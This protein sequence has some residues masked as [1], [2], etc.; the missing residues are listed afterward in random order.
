MFVSSLAVLLCVVSASAT[1]TWQT[2]SP[3]NHFTK[4]LAPGIFVGGRVTT[5]E[6]AYIAE[7][8]YKS[9]L[10]TTTY[11]SA[12][13]IN[14]VTGDFPSVDEEM[15]LAKSLGM[16]AQYFAASFTAEWAETISQAIHQ[17]PKPIFIHC[18]VGYKGSLFTELHLYLNGVVAADDIYQNTLTLGWDY[19]ADS[20][21]VALINSVTGLTS[22]VTSPS[23]EQ[24]LADGENSYKYYY[25][26][27]RIGNDYWYNIGQVLSTQVNSIASAGYKSVISF[28]SNGESTTRL[29]T[30]NPTGSIENFEFSDSN[31]KYNVTAEQEAFEGVGIHFYY[32]PV[33]GNTA[34]T[35]EEFEAYVPTISEAVSY[36]PVLVHCRSGYR[37]GGYIT[38]YLAKQQGQCTS[39]AVKEA[40]RIGL[41]FDN[42]ETD[43]TVMNFYQTVLGC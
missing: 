25:W 35:V 4:R 18:N 17:M 19:Q 14:G 29:S 26:A 31:G 43:E 21:A 24:T 40:R 38:A 12:T 10:V 39:W 30:D 36:G 2:F 6:L 8:G 11:S 15:E 9:L 5:R 34:W 42:L 3:Y 20:S 23:I 16:E 41:S 22:Q 7:A 32:L 1:F 27:H 28:R 13:E 33:T 37:S